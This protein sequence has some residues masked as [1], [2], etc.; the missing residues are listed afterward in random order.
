MMAR[1]EAVEAVGLGA[2]EVTLRG[3][4][5]RVLH[6]RDLLIVHTP[7]TDIARFR[8]KLADIRKVFAQFGDQLGPNTAV[9]WRRW[10]ELTDDTAVNE[11]FARN[12][13]PERD[14]ADLW[15]ARVLAYPSDLFAP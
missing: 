15:A 13:I 7:F 3:Q 10:L 2:H 8:S 12:V 4:A 9:H 14:L 11:E 6:A 5:Q 1:A